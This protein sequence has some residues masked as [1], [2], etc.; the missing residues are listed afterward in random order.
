LIG[1]VVARYFMIRRLR[2]SSLVSILACGVAVAVFV[3]SSNVP[4]PLLH[5]GLLA[6]V[7]ALLIHSLAGG[8]GPVAWLLSRRPLVL[9]G[10]ASYALYILQYPVW[11]WTDLLLG[12]IL[13]P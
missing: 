13:G 1:M 8:T 3:F 4:E 11:C 7:F 9:L 12:R 5:N 10:E 6:P 2:G